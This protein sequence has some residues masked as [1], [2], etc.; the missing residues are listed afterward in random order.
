M[1]K[2]SN[3]SLQHKQFMESAQMNDA[4]F[5][6][7]FYRF[8]ALAINMFKWN[9]LPDTIDER[10]LEYTLFCDGMAVFFKDEI[11]EEYLALQCMIG[12]ELN[13]YRIPKYRRAYAVNG[14][15]KVL[16]PENSVII[17]NNYLR[18]PSFRTTQLYAQRVADIDRTIDVN[19]A[20][21]KTPMLILCEES[22]KLTMLNVYKNY[23]GN[24]P[25]IYGNKG[26]F[27]VEDFTVLKTDAPFVADKLEELKRVKIN[28]A[29]T[30]YGIE[31]DSTPKKERKVGA[32]VTSNLG[33]VEAQRTIM[34][35]GRR[36]AARQINEMFGLNVSVEF[37]TNMINNVPVEEYNGEEYVVRRDDGLDLEAK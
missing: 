21:Q 37:N 24:M 35:N 13:V 7:W 30:F 8:Q 12:G 26:G 11:M 23:A 5:C 33:E 10:F 4:T 17:F 25:V 22:Q 20:Q 31:N 9:G 18:Q 32:E 14:Y 3:P 1:P 28:E 34:L 15:N 27:K 6:D 2:Y 29:M 16:T 36:Q 19:V